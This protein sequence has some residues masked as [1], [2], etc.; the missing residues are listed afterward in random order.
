[1]VVVEIV[2]AWLSV[3]VVVQR[4]ATSKSQLQTANPTERHHQTIRPSQSTSFLHTTARMTN[5]QTDQAKSVH[6]RTSLLL[7]PASELVLA[8]QMKKK[9]SDPMKTTSQM[10]SQMAHTSRTNEICFCLICH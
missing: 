2:V 8:N 6:Q 9:N 7:Q 5:Q 3:V 10:T 1:M 4:S